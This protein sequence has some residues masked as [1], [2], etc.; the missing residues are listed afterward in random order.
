LEKVRDVVIVDAV[1]TPIG[2]Y[3]GA[4]IGV[5]TDG[6]AATV[7]GALVERNPNIPP[8]QIDYSQ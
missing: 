5:R 6:L 8:E 3:K 7:I 1:R 2:S 4:L